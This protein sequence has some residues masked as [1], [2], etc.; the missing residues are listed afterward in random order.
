MEYALRFGF[1]VSNNKAKYEAIITGLNLAHSMEA[2]Q[3]EVCNDSQLVVKHIE[4]DYKAKGEKMIRYLK[5]VRELLKKSIQV[6]V[7]HIP[8]TENSWA[9]ALAKL[10]TASQ[11]DLDR[12][13]PIEHLMEPSVDVSSNEVLLVMTAPSLI[14]P[15]W[16]YLLNVI[17]PSDP[18]EASKLRARSARFALLRGT[19]YKWGFPHSS[20]NA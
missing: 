19:L 10:A 17:L 14:D 7:R 13:V 15:I 8:R 5:K 20:S 16:D 1:W 11:E 18:K 9:D 2:D 6:Q 12:R 3:L 4:D